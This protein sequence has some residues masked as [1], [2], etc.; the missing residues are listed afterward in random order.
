[1]KLSTVYTLFTLV[2]ASISFGL[3][4]NSLDQLDLNFHSAPEP[5]LST[6]F[7]RYMVM[8]Q[9][10]NSTSTYAGS[11]PSTNSNHFVHRSSVSSRPDKPNNFKI[12][13]APS[14]TSNAQ[15]CS[16]TMLPARQNASKI[17]A[18]DHKKLNDLIVKIQGYTVVALCGMWAV[19]WLGGQFST[20]NMQSRVSFSPSKTAGTKIVFSVA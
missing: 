10:I 4:I 14:N 7:S 18:E 15:G 3:K 13:S 11:R 8:E 6:I 20:I 2:F 5:E 12:I 17:S 1:M 19:L 16:S 9:Q